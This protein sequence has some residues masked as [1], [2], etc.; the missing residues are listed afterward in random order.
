MIRE[1]DSLAGTVVIVLDGGTDAGRQLAQRKLADGHRVVVVA[2]HA[3]DAVEVLHGH[4]AD[5]I[6]VI[7]AD[8][9]DA[10]QWSR[11]TARV[12]ERFGRVDAVVRAAGATLRASA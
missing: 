6:M 4:S 7:A 3:C 8:V 12:T 1:T 9:D 10:R 11:V 5:R 2:R